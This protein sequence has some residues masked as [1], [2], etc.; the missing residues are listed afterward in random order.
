MIQDHGLQVYRYLMCNSAVPAEAYDPSESL[1][2]SQLVHPDW[3]GYP[4]NSWAASWHTLFRDDA[5]DDRKH[6]GWPGRFSGVLDVAVNFYSAGDE[7]LELAVDNDVG[8][9]TGIGDSL[10]H[11]AWYKQKLF[12]GRILGFCLHRHI[13][14]NAAVQK[15]RLFKNGRRDRL[16]AP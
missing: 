1:R 12:K 13:Y 2:V 10:A 9:L 3:E 6:L 4:T 11:H 16:T 14:I 5:D 8:I 7:V 15:R